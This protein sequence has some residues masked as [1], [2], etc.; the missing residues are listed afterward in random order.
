MTLIF[1]I[2]I[3][4]IL[5]VGLVVSV[6]YLVRWILRFEKKIDDLGVNLNFATD[7][8]LIN[9][10][11]KTTKRKIAGGTGGERELP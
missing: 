11:E 3:L 1:I 5:V 6:I 2:I 10:R 9:E 4:A 7:N 8:Y